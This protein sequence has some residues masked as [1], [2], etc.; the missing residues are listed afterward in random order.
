[1][2]RPRKKSVRSCSH[3][4]DPFGYGQRAVDFLR[5]LKHPKSRLPDKAFQLDP[6]QEDI[7][8]R[9]YGPCDEH[10]NRIVQS[11]VILV[12]RGNRKTSLAAAL[13]LLHAHGPEAVPA[14]EVL[15]AAVDKKQAKIGLAEATGVIQATWGDIWRK[16]QAARLSDAASGIRDQSYKNRVLFPNESFLE[17]LSND[18]GSQHGRTPVFA[19]CDEIHAWKKRDLWD[20]IDTG[21]TKTDNS[22]R[23]TITTAGRGQENLA[24]EVIDYAR[25]VA[26]GEIDDPSVLA[27]LYET[28]A[29]ADWKDEKVWHAVNPGLK[30]GYPSLAGM[31]SRVKEAEHK[32]ALRDAFRQLRLN[33]WLDYSDAPFVEMPIYDEGAFPVDLTDLEED[34]CWIGVDLSSNSDLTAV[35]AA[36]GDPETGYSVHPWFFCPADNLRRRAERDGVPYPTWAEDGLIIPTSGNV[37][38]FVAVENHIR[39]LC[40]RFNV[41]E[42]AFDPHMG[43]VM[44]SNLV[45]DGFPAVEMRQGW[46]TMAPAVKELERAIVGRKFRHGGHPVLRW[47]FS[48]IAIETDKAGNI[49]FHK[50]KS[51]DRIDG[52]V[53]AAMAVGRC[54]AGDSNVSSYETF[55]GDIEEWAYA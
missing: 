19:L 24:F 32:P 28:P 27:F 30:H 7:V 52:A 5:S 10:G 29:E 4:P 26:R 34:P 17:A 6:W 46:V 35:V 36:W 43:R 40:A 15:F 41:Q 51:K 14:G 37:V 16:G 3:I 23:I 13:T 18:A 38:D 54:M 21:L 53:A 50:G 25:R 48:N 45:E 9:I 33:V 39:E 2:K 8:R 31:R 20:V 1:M 49:S 11:V 22:L 12:P 47:H 55:D 42:I 44:M